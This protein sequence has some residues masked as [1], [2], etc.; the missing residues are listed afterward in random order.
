M[1]VIGS[2]CALAAVA[3][4]RQARRGPEGDSTRADQFDLLFL[5]CMSLTPRAQSDL[6]GVAVLFAHHDDSRLSL[7]MAEQLTRVANRAPESTM[8]VI[9]TPEPDT[10]A[11]RIRG[12]IQDLEVAG[13]E[14]LNFA[15]RAGNKLIL[16][17]LVLLR[18][19]GEAVF[20]W[21]GKLDEGTLVAVLE[22]FISGADPEI[23][24]PG[25]GDLIPA[26]L[27][28]TLAV[29]RPGAG[30]PDTD[31]LLLLFA[32]PQCETCAP[33]MDTVL[34]RAEKASV[35]CAVV[36][37][38][39]FQVQGREKADSTAPKIILD[40]YFEIFAAMRVNIVPTLVLVY[41]DGSIAARL[42]GPKDENAIDGVLA[43]LLPACSARPE[44]LLVKPP[45]SSPE[46]TDPIDVKRQERSE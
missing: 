42:D 29:R 24:I 44:S 25:E 26:L 2:L 20:E 36:T 32:D 41:G 38:S 5:R 8:F 39:P 37:S 19:P 34:A 9:V 30:T 31:T 35:R 22:E 28:D 3:I 14:W 13:R 12:D 45:A 6:S 4:L 27:R 1:L 43:R 17:A 33:Y 7:P 11:F 23:S 40:P 10:L 16:P 21:V 46:A 18:A 15:P